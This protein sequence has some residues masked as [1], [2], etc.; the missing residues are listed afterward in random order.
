MA[1]G[2]G[3]ERVADDTRLD[4]GVELR[5]CDRLPLGLETEENTTTTITQSRGE[6]TCTYILCKSVHWTR[7]RDHR[8]LTCWIQ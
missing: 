4:G 1:C 8:S 3:K 2:D 6:A 7:A 5:S